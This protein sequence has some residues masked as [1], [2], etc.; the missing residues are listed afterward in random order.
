VTD[1][2]GQWWNGEAAVTEY[3]D[4]FEL[5]RSALKATHW[6]PNSETAP[7]PFFGGWVC[8]LSYELARTV[9]ALPETVQD[10]QAF[11]HLWMGFYDA[12]YLYSEADQTWTLACL[13]ADQEPEEEVQAR[14]RTMEARLLAESALEDA[15][16]LP[17]ALPAPRAH[18]TP[19]EYRQAVARAIE[20]I[21]AGDI[22]QVNLSQRFD[23]PL[24]RAGAGLMGELLRHN[25]APYSA[26]LD[27][28]GQCILSASPELFLEL[29]GDTVETRPIKG[30]RPRGSTPEEDRRL[31]GELEG[32]EKDR[33]ELTMITDLLRNDLGRVC[34]Y[35][36]V[37]VV[38]A[39]RLEAY[40][41][42]FHT[43]SLIQGTLRD[44]ADRVDLLR[45]CWPG[46]SITGAPKVRAMEIIDELEPTARHLYT[47]SL[48]TLGI[49]GSLC[50]NL[51][52][53]TL[54]CDGEKLT[55]QVGG[56]IVADSTP[57]GEY[58]ETLHKAEGL[59]RALNIKW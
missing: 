12:V 28:G 21:R 58:D 23:L 42:V 27:L 52:I 7:L 47:G 56:G 53:R 6:A 4:P 17:S 57:E 43:E 54:L 24:P 1:N 33:A 50:L 5:M 3:G 19:D 8:A 44:G 49:D 9:E 10:D 11:P 36:S 22:F 55:F 39:R 13:Q 46:G 35:G 29:H 25:P 37:A 48:G 45:A 18:F 32:S 30:T 26:Y 15:P 59:L 40:D 2:T 16:A 51:L 34:R 41:T 20:Y 31:R 38:E 14:L